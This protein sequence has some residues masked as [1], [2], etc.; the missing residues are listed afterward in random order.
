[1]AE[2]ELAVL[3]VEDNPGDARLVEWALRHEPE[4]RFRTEHAPRLAA[5]L[6]R[7]DRGGID[8]VLL[9]LGL[10]DSR[11]DEGVRRIHART[12]RVAIVVLSGAEDPVLV[13]RAIEAGAQDFQVKGIFPGGHLTRVLGSALRRQRLEQELATAGPDRVAGSLAETPEAVAWWPASGAPVASPA[14]LALAGLPADE[15]ARRPSWIADLIGP[16]SGRRP[17]DPPAA[18]VTASPVPGAGEIEYV[19]RPGPGPWVLLE[20][21]PRGSGSPG[22]PAPVPGPSPIDPDSY[23]QLLELAGGDPTFVPALLT[24]FLDESA[25]AF[26]ALDAAAGRGDAPAAADLAHRLKSSSA[27]VGA[28]AL[29]R[30]LAELEREARHAH[31][32]EMRGIARRVTR[33]YPAVARELTTRRDAARGSGSAGST[34]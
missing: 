10:P 32:E 12:P 31:L 23:S 17:S 34:G 22:A 21:R 14:F 27:Q 1:M 9:D 7:L 3:I 2:A 25:R 29:S 19:V 16:S 4:A 13:R 6:E 28:L 5:A 8:L 15:L 20:L 18:G 26:P 11:A 33:D 30:R 24:A